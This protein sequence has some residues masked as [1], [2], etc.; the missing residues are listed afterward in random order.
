MESDGMCGEH[1]KGYSERFSEFSTQLP[2]NNQSC[3]HLGLLRY[4]L[5]VA[6]VSW[7][8]ADWAT[9]RIYARLVS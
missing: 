1:G 2:R 7:G 3:S 4:V 8:D 6:N 5:I 9:H